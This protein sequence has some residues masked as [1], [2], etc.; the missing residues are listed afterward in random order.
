MHIP[1]ENPARERG[2]LNGL[3]SAHPLL[4]IHAV[5][6]S[7]CLVADASRALLGAIRQTATAA[8]YCVVQADS[9][10]ELASAIHEGPLLTAKR[11]LLV[12]GAAWANQCAISISVAVTQR[13]QLGLP[14]ARLILVYEPGSLGVV[15]RPII[16]HC[17]TIAVLEQPFEMEALRTAASLAAPAPA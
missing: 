16:H 11:L 12:L 6:D 14:S 7:V 9:T 3:R 4:L 2:A 8:G 10:L 17:E 15:D 5:S 1:G 13:H